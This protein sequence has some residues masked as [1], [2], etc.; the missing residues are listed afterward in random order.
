ML[1][2]SVCHFSPLTVYPHA[3]LPFVAMTPFTA[4]NISITYL[5]YKLRRTVNVVPGPCLLTSIQKY[6]QYS[7]HKWIKGN[8]A[9]LLAIE[10][11]QSCWRWMYF[12][13]NWK[14]TWYL[15]PSP[16]HLYFRLTW[17]G[18]VTD[19][20]ERFGF[21]CLLL[22]KELV[23]RYHTTSQMLHCW[24]RH[25]MGFS[26][27]LKNAHPRWKEHIPTASLRVLFGFNSR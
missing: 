3:D 17:H 4:Q 23:S 7:W 20:T 21:V 22:A 14:T 11:L 2:V 19:Q 1:H 13:R 9:V 25:R 6:C 27:Y 26:K 18:E 12:L 5:A 16:I 15:K 8:P 24:L 10:I